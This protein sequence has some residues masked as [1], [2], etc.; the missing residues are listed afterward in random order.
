VKTE[1]SAKSSKSTKPH[2]HS[3]P[4]VVVSTR[5][6]P[7]V[8]RELVRRKKKLGHKNLAM[9]VAAAISYYVTNVECA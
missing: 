1:N 4:T 7:S 8:R 2:S 3:S 9:T 6:A 5:I